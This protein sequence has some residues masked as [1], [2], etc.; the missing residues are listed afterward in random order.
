VEVPL[1]QSPTELTKR[2]KAIIQDA[3]D[4]QMPTSKK[5]KKQPF[6]MYRLTEGAEPKLRAVREMLTVY[7][8][9]YLKRPDLRGKNLLDATHSLYVGRKSKRHAKVPTPLLSDSDGDTIR[10]MRNLRRYITKAE[11]IVRNVANGE[12][13]GKY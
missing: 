10:S 8:D 6:S 13:P 1:I 3:F 5:S 12:F 9:V 7:R 11:R 4:A 2:V